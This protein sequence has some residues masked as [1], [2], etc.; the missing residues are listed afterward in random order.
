MN[1]IDNILKKLR[2]GKVGAF[3][4]VNGDIISNEVDVRDGEEYGDFVNYSSHWDLW[5]AA[6]RYYPQ[7]KN[8]EYDTFPRGR[9]V[10]N[11]KDRKYIIYLDP[12]LNNE[13][14]IDLV[15][16]RFNLRNG[17]YVVDD[18]DEHYQSSNHPPKDLYIDENTDFKESLDHYVKRE[19]Y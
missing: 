6:Q 2:E 16:D 8:I 19:T 10:F 13:I 4:I 11:K 3:F 5:R 14:D 18:R 12:K 1:S 7:L 9:V 15:T 17:T